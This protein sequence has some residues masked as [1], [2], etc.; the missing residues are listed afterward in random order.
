MKKNET[1]GCEKKNK[2]FQN[3]FF[4]FFVKNPEFWSLKCDQI[5]VKKN[6]TLGC[7][8]KIQKISRKKKFEKP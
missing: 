5:P 2:K 7:E 8:K 6:E 3:F 1:L 4:N